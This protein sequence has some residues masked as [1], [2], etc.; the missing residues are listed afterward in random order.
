M[1]GASLMPTARKGQRLDHASQRADNRF[2]SEVNRV[3]R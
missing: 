1:S 2:N 3:R